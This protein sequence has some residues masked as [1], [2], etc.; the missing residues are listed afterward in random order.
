MIEPS[1]PIS[2]RNSKYKSALLEW[3]NFYFLY[4]YDA[5]S[6]EGR[7]QDRREGVVNSA[8]AVRLSAPEHFTPVHGVY[9]PPSS[10][11]LVVMG[12]VGVV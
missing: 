7:S 11:S 9:P 10:I 2:E 1:R 12:R 4:S 3:H 8:L 5:T 6:V